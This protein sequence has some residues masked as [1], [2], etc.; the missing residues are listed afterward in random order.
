MAGN[1]VAGPRGW[2]LTMNSM[3]AAL[4]S[5]EEDSDFRDFVEKAEDGVEARGSV[6]KELRKKIATRFSALLELRQTLEDEVRGLQ[7]EKNTAEMT[8]LA[9][10]EEIAR[11]RASLREVARVVAEAA[12]PPPPVAQPANAVN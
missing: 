5:L 8:I 12:L 3:A 4:E 6:K 7:V 9:K 11:L 1:G 2:L 10:D